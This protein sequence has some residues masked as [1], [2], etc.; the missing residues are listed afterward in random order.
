MLFR[1]H[2][3]PGY[4][5]EVTPQDVEAGVKTPIWEEYRRILKDKTGREG[6]GL[7]ERQ[8]FYD[9]AAGEELI[10]LTGETALY[11]NV[12]LYKGVIQTA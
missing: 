2:P 10:V 5:M 9:V 12:L 6:L 8:A 1:S 11:A 3:E 4:V 7:I